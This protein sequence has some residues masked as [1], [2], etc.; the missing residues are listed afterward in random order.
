MIGSQIR[1]LRKAENMTQ[2]ELAS[3]LFVSQQAV[4]K[5]ERG[6]AT[7]N[8]EAIAT[9]AKIFCVSADVLLGESRPPPSTGKARAPAETQD[10][11]P[12]APAA[13]AN[14]PATGERYL[15]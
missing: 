11:M 13:A 7:P 8:P 2:Q 3:K 1:A 6:E 15:Y 12:I 10:A 14:P 4:S 9:M 5:W